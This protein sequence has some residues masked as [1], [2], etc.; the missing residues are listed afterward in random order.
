MAFNEKH[1]VED[2][3]IKQLEQRGWSEDSSE[4]L[5]EGITSFWRRVYYVHVIL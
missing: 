5:R 4:D 1:L 3:I 2:Y